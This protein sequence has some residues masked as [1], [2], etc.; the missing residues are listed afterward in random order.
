MIKEFLSCYIRATPKSVEKRVLWLVR[1][2]WEHVPFYRQKMQ[3]AGLSASDFNSLDD[4]INNFPETTSAEYRAYQQ[5]GKS[6][7]LVDERRPLSGLI[8]DRSSGSSGITIS[9]F[10]SPAEY[11]M[12]RARALWHLLQAGLKPWHRILAVLPPLQ[13]RKNVSM[14]ILQS[15]GIFRRTAVDYTMP[16]ETIVEVIRRQ[17]IN[18]IYGQ[19]S[20]IRLIADH[21]MQHG[22]Q[23]PKLEL[24]IPGAERV[25]QYDREYLSQVFRPRLFGEFYGAT[26]PYLIATRKW[27][28]DYQ[29]D[30]KAVFLS[31]AAPDYEA[32]LTKGNILVTSLINEAQPI[33]KLELGDRVA[34]RSYGQLTKL[35]ATIAKVEGRSNDYLHLPDGKK[36]SG[37]TFYASLEYFPFMRQFKIVQNDVNDCTVILRISEKTDEKKAQVEAVLKQLLGGRI[38]YEIEYVDAIPVDPNGKTKILV[39]KVRDVK[40]ASLYR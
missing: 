5:T 15:L 34:V 18:V 8:E 28:N 30:Y 16:I 21:Y 39:S 14:S 26:E 37:A 33:L 12:N 9:V 25:D 23:P 24:L 19:K 4:Y 20:F 11:E 29:V 10:R 17:R 6:Q 2:A 36:I 27:D 7:G 3:A 31:L 1:H 35:G 13:M 32:R 22:I 38:A 40:S